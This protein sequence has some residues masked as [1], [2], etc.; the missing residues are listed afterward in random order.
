MEAEAKIIIAF[1]FNRSGK[2]ALKESEIYLPLS[3]ELGWF[4]ATEAHD[5]VTY[6][7][8]QH[9][10][11]HKEGLLLPNFP[12][13]KTTIPVGFTPSKK[14]FIEQT[15]EH[16]TENILDAMVTHISNYTTQKQEDIRRKIHHTAQERHLTLEVAA[17]YIARTHDVDVT[18]WYDRIEHRLFTENTG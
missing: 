14:F 12:V 1:L 15:G 2:P 6:A 7:L 18:E 8:T 9:L 11:V 10:L 3:M 17:L 4:S 5:F 13:E 16:E